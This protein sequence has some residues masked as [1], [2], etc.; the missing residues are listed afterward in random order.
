MVA[1]THQQDSTS[2]A[3]W[4]Q[5][6]K[7]AGMAPLCLDWSGVAKLVVVAAHPDDETLG[8][9]GL[10]QQAANHSVP[11]VLI[12]A[13]WGEKSHPESPTHGPAQLA[14]LRVA[15]L[16]EA[17][18]K[19]S[20][21]T[22]LRALA[23]PDGEVAAHVTALEQEIVASA[24][25]AGTALIV[26]PWSADGHT[27]HEAAGA[28][29]ARA[30]RAGGSLFLEYPIWMWH[31][32][33]PAGSSP[34]D[35]VPWPALRR[36]ELN[37][38]QRRTKVSAMASHV[39]QVAAL[40]PERGNEAL[41][42]EAVLAHFDR[43]FETYIDVAGTFTPMG[44]AGSSWLRGQF[45]TIHANG[46]EPWN[47]Q[48]WYEQRKRS[49]LLAGLDR[50]VFAS[51]LEIGTSTGALLEELAPRC[52]Q[53]LGI[54]ASAQAVD[55]ARRR[56]AH[57]DTVSCRL[58]VFPQDWPAG[59]FDLFVLSESGYYLSETDL[60]ALRERMVAS[61]APGAVLAACHWRHPIAGWP[62]DGAEVH[63]RLRADSRWHLSGSYLENDFQLDFF[64]L[65]D[66]K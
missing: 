13:T 5:S 29:A 55:S 52:Q 25:S 19:L 21:T 3:S 64:R 57:L 31:W 20:P 6:P 48:A 41:L 27:D 15:E 1:F 45:D 51:G 35:L 61:A 42:S 23:L 8:A 17:L 66:V 10:I 53:L 38:A 26:A 36:L 24:R 14:K 9:A 11:T 49:L 40:S 56:T 34:T 7:M 46:A 63:R 43:P 65:K 16:Q 59:T 44:D 50:Q 4:L 12:V 30:A 47:P 18:R 22:S 33:D 2:E 39:S 62:L 54:D 37:T 58:G 60:A 28:A 32:A